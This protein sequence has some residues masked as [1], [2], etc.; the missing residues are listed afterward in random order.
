MSYENN[1]IK[2][3][4]FSFGLLVLTILL[5]IVFPVLLTLKLPTYK[6]DTATFV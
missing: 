6:G 1:E 3:R 4:K 5:L 2:E